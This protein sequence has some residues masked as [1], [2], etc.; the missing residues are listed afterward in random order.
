MVLGVTVRW[1]P[2]RF[3]AWEPRRNPATFILWDS[4]DVAGEWQ[5]VPT[6]AFSD[7]V[8]TAAQNIFNRNVARLSENVWL[9][10]HNHRT[11]VVRSGAPTIEFQFEDPYAF[12]LSV[13][14]DRALMSGGGSMVLRMST[15]DTV[16]RMPIMYHAWSGLHN[17]WIHAVRRRVRS[18]GR[19]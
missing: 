19:A 9:V 10:T 11:D 2:E 14:A 4:A 1:K 16:Y 5:L 15:G 3:G 17:R 12:H 7:T 13:P 8:P 6:V 18:S